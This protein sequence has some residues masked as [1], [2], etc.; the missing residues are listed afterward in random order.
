MKLPLYNGDGHYLPARSRVGLRRAEL[1]KLHTPGVCSP[2]LV[3]KI[4]AGPPASETH[5]RIHPSPYLMK[6]L[7]I[8]R[9]QIIYTSSPFNHITA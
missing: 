2:M 7:K 3:P 9:Y 6:F 4:E 1:G 8:D 5:A